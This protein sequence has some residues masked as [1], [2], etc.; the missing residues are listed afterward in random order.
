LDSTFTQTT[1]TNNTVNALLYSAGSLYVGGSFTTYRGSTSGNRLM[2]LDPSS[3][4]LDATFN[5]SS[6]GPTNGAVMALAISSGSLFI[7]GTFQGYR[8][9]TADKASYITKVNVST[10]AVDSGFLNSD[11]SKV[12]S[13]DGAVYAVAVSSDNAT[14]YLGG[15]FS[16]YRSTGAGKIVSINVTNGVVNGEVSA[17]A[18][19]GNVYAIALSGTS[20]FVGGAFTSYNSSG[21]AYRLMKLNKAAGVFS[22]D[23]TFAPSVNSNGPSS[24]VRA[25]A[26][27]SGG[28]SI[29]IGGLFTSYRTTLD[30][31]KGYYLAKVNGTNGGLD[32]TFNSAA[33]TGPS[34]DVYAL[35]MSSDGT[36]LYVGGAFSSYRGASESQYFT[37]VSTTNG[38]ASW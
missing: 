8:A 27:S 22:L 36:K 4:A 30:A 38:V 1:G 9:E 35:Q 2:K 23:L 32:L 33:N 12:G 6:S 7:G 11:S 37:P 31:S 21:K 3:G 13:P 15:A 18:T 10:G 28:A 24:D 34:A 5:S 25:I 20:M 26:V 17:S 14:V 29:F 19:G 16:T